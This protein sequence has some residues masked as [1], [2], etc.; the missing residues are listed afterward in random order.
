[1]R[2]FPF[3]MV[4][5]LMIT[6]ACTDTFPAVA[7]VD[8]VTGPNT[9]SSAI[10]INGTIDEKTLEEFT[11]AA[12][13]ARMKQPENMKQAQWPL[14]I[15]LNSLGGSVPD[16]MEIGEIIRRKGFP[17]L[18]SQGD[19]CDSAC[20]L[21]LAAGVQ[22]VAMGRVGIHRPHFDEKL[23]AQLGQTEAREKYAQMEESVRKYLSHMGMPDTLYAA[24]L[25]VSSDDAR[26][27]SHEELVDYGLDGD[28]PAWAEWIRAKGIQAIGVEK[29]ATNVSHDAVYLACYTHKCLRGQCNDGDDFE[30][31]V[32]ACEHRWCSDVDPEFE[33]RIKPCGNHSGDDYVSC[34]KAVEQRMIQKYT[35]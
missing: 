19:E 2:R 1:M 7:S 28:D 5:C 33:K 23:F 8:F 20:V 11:K 12:E 9:G 31:C 13:D 32:S 4:F 34:V 24:M 22:R 26:Y 10:L 18:V 27:L 14:A 6:L 17:T 25:R 15:V 16:A 21:I 3:L 30:R 35:E 29:Y